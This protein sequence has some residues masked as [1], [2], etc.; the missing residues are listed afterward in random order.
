MNKIKSLWSRYKNEVLALLAVLV[1]SALF[2]PSNFKGKAPKQ[3]DIIQYKGA[4]SE[5]MAYNKSDENIIWTNALFAGMPAYAIQNQGT[6]TVLQNLKFP[7][8]PRIWAQLFLYLIC[9]FIMLK[10]FEVR[11]WLAVIG[12]IG[13]GFATENFTI[14][15]VGHNTKAAAIGYLPLVIAG[16]QYLFRKKYLLG[17]TVLSAGFALQIFVN[18]VQIT[19]YGGF[20]VVLFFIFQLVKHIQENKI[21]DYAIAAILALAGAGIAVGANSLNLLLLNEYAEDSIRGESAL[22]IT[23][24]SQTND[25]VQNGLT[26]DYV[27]SY[28]MGWSDYV[29][30]IIPNYS[31]GKNY[32]PEDP[33]SQTANLY[34]GQIGSTSGPKYLGVTMFILM[35]L[36]LVMVKGPLK[37]WIVSVILLTIVLSMGGNHFVGINTFM[38]EHFPL[39]NKF[40]APS[41]M[42]VLIQ[43]SM[44]LLAM[45]GLEEFFK[46][47]ANLSSFKKPLIIASSAGIAIIILAGFTGT[48]FND[49]N[50]VPIKNESGRVVYDRDTEQAKRVLQKRNPTPSEINSYLDYFSAERIKPMEKDAKISLFFTLAILALVWLAFYK[51]MD[52]KYVV[53]LIGILVLA[54]LWFVGK[55]QLNDKHFKKASYSPQPFE[56][57]AAD[58]E[59]KRDQSYYRVLDVTESTLNSNRCANFHKSI[60]GYS[61]AKIRRYQDLWDWYLIDDLQ[62][63]KVD[64]NPILNMLNMKYFIYPNQQQQGGQ[65]MYGQN[66]NA[67]GNAWI[68]PN[69]RIVANADSAI[70]ALGQLDT[71]T[72]GVVEQEFAGRVSKNNAVDSNATITFDKYHPEQMEY[73][74][75]SSQESNVVFSEV[76]Y[77]K[78][79][80][81]YIDNELVDHYRVNYILRGLRVPA[82][83]HKIVF[84]FE[85]KTYELGST[86]SLSFGAIIYLLIALSLGLWIKSEF[87]N[88]KEVQ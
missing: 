13:I 34:Y 19:Y 3:S 15:A 2:V 56:P 32:N 43:I 28:S 67:L 33:P 8:H 40:R 36:G 70:L 55:R 58:L 7:S 79:W 54:D 83:K 81:A 84:K 46:N 37:W 63:S 68:V 74:Y 44:G 29:A 38:Y 85:P 50:T 66:A 9:A 80:N 60:G 51:K 59:I 30:T 52:T 72:N 16:C 65:P 35:L 6:K 73:T 25:N 17:L 82:G 24:D 49:F 14:L 27:F 48:M 26:K 31:G 53:L 18:H 12:A 1:I 4:A 61:A 10:S 62:K 75:A 21:K 42:I 11:T 57:Y 64:N 69:I 47:H 86:L 88:S 5:I 77:D 87:F 78:G 39:Y 22:T 71:R 76:F 45:L 41:M 20:M 23:P